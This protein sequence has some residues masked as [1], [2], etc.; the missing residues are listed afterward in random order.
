MSLLAHW[1]DEVSGRSLGAIVGFIVGSGLTW[2]VARWRRYR[3]KRSI[4]RG[5]ARDT[6][7]IA[8]HLVESEERPGSNGQLARFAKCLRI[9]SIGQA[10]LDRV[11]PNGHLAAVFLRRAWRVTSDD[12]LISMT[13]AEGSYLLETLM[14][15]VCDR[16]A[17]SPYEHDLWVMAPCCEPAELSEH[18][19]I[20]LILITVSDLALFESWT[21]CRDVHVEHGSDGSRVLTLMEMAR[22]FRKEHNAIAKMRGE[23]KRTRHAESMYVLDLAMDQRWAPIPTKPVPWGRYAEILKNM[24]LE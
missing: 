15:F 23:G 4:F 2:M 8:Q 14:N 3:A 1:S 20:T 18:Q 24:E 10:P 17:N 13:G 5:D 22:R 19:P 11:I 7:I 9:R 6:V 21:H 12:T 16:V